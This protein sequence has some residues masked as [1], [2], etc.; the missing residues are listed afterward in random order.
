MHG[1]MTAGAPTGSLTQPGGVGNIA[2]EDFARHPLDLRMTFEAEIGIALH[3]ELAIDRAVRVMANDAT[4]PHRL[5]FEN[6]G[7]GLLPMTLSAAFVLASHCQATLWLEDIRAMRIVALKA[8]HV[9]FIYRMPLRQMELRFDL[10]MALITRRRIFG[11]IHDELPAAAA[12]F[13]M[14]ASRAVAR[15]TTGRAGHRRV[16]HLHPRMWTGRKDPGDVAVAFDA[17]SITHELCARN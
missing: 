10:R 14:F 7:T 16:L 8:I 4:F 13:D 6:K 17:R 3:E 5:V 11:R 1:R 12:R 2:S 15:F 9:P